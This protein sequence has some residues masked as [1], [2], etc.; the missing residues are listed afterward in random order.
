MEFGR[1]LDVIRA[2]EK[3][4]V[5]YILVGGVAVNLHGIVRATEDIDF[6]LRPEPENI[7]RLKTALRSLWNDPQIDEIRAEDFADYPTLRYG[8]PG[9]ELVIDILTRLGTAFRFEDLE[10]E[11]LTVESVRVRV[12]TPE[13]LVRVNCATNRPIETVDAAIHQKPRDREPRIGL[14][15]FRDFEEARRALWVE[16]GD[17]QLVPRIRSLWAFARRLAPGAAPRGIRRFSTFEEANRDRDIWIA[18]RARALREA[19]RTP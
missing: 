1:F 5:D 17:P 8:P 4:R 7:E 16:P 10:A 12:A 9:D 15:R 3:A 18:P 6:F 11:T 2:F 14:Q 13:T 19:R